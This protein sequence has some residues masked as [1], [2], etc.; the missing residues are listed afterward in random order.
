MGT[1]DSGGI[2][3]RNF[4]VGTGAAYL[5]LAFGG[6]PL[7]GTACSSKEGTL[8]IGVTTP[9]TG[10]VTDKGRVLEDGNKDAIKYVNA[11]LGGAGGYEIE[12]MWMD[13][14]YNAGTMVNDV[15]KFMSDGC[16]MF[17]TSSSTMMAAVKTMANQAGFP[18]LAAYSAPAIYR[19]P[20]HVYGQT[21]DYGDD[22]VVFA[23]YYLANIWH[24]EGKPKMAMHILNNSTGYGAYDGAR[25]MADELGIEI[26]IH[27][28]HTASTTSEITSLT[29]IKALNPDI[30]FIASTPTPSA[31]II[32]NANELGMTSGDMII[33]CGH[34]GM[35][36]SLINTAG[37]DICEG[38]YGLFPTVSWGE[39]VA[40]MAKMTEYCQANHPNDYGNMDYITSWCQ[41][42]IMAKIVSLAVEEV[43]FDTLAKGDA[44]AW[45]ALEEHG[46]KALDNYDVQGLQGPVSYSEGDNRLC[47]SLRVF[48]VQ[49]GEITAIT[50]W[51]ESPVIEYENFEWFGS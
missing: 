46:I 31:V 33:V 4:I 6:L 3:R 5:A 9:S 26:I 14:G 11:E 13:D 1:K 10:P 18:G 32:K 43:G 42:L 7:L 40:G 30:L 41:S 37:A 47:K 8:K 12:L 35:T 28:E 16:L 17:G 29:E 22:W 21:P 50:D 23:Q 2:S 39:N 49:S 15:N 27:R 25:A 51:I 48:Q 24:G 20:E 45:A 44:D 34:A 19:P 38:V 36:Q